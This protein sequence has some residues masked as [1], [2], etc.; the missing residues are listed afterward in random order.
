MNVFEDI[1]QIASRLLS[2]ADQMNNDD[3]FQPVKALEDSANQLKR[4]FSGSWLGYHANTYYADFIPSPAGAVWSQEWGDFESYTGLGSRGNWIQYTPE[5]VR[6]HI[7]QVAGNPNVSPAQEAAASAIKTFENAI[8]E[9]TS[10]LTLHMETKT[11][12]FIEKLLNDIEKIR[13]LSANSIVQAWMPK[14]QIMSRDQ[15]AIGQGYMTPPHIQVL[16]EVKAINHAF[17]ICHRAGETA[18]KLASHLERKNKRSMADNRIGTNIFLGHGRS[19]AWREL[20]DFIQDRLSLPCDEFNRVPIAGMTNIARLSEMMD[21]AA[22]AFL[23]MTAED[24]TADGK[25]QARMNVIHE[26]GLFQGR[27]GFEKAIV[28]LEEGCEEFSNIQGLGQIR[29]P[30]GDISARFEDIRQVLEREGLV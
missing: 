9:I 15:N 11:D 5:Y 23:I 27:L 3:L 19:S 16:A 12:T 26:V 20:K 1:Y 14:G 2:T 6:D 13:P 29:F 8:A 17:D 22:F 28:L 18:Q 24:E 25:T 4:S 10:I 7:F 21:S 30:K